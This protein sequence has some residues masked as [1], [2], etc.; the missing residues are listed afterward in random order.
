MQS[1]VR[2]PVLKTYDHLERGRRSDHAV[3][4]SESLLDGVQAGMIG[5]SASPLPGQ[6]AEQLTKLTISCHQP[7]TA[8]ALSLTTLQ[9]LLLRAEGTAQR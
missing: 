8:K 6:A 1:E 2:P 9:A 4:R 5:G 7:E 3:I